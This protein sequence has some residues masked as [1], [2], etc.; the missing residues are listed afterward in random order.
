MSTIRFG[1]IRCDL[2]AI[3]YANIM[4]PHDVTVLRD[5][6]YGKG[7]DYYFYQDY[8]QPEQL[9]FPI[10]PGFELTRVWSPI[11][12]D[13][14]NMAKL[15]TS[16]PKV[17]ETFEEVSDD[18]DLVLIANC[19]EDKAGSDHLE[20]A[21]P[22]IGKG[23]PTFIDKPMAYEVSDAR[24]CVELAQEHNTPI[25]SLSILREVPHVA[26]FRNRFA[27]LGQPQ[28]AL[29]KGGNYRMAGMVHAISFAQHLFG[30]GVESV[31]SM[32][33]EGKP[34]IIHLDY[35]DQ[36]DKP[37][38]GVTLNCDVGDTYHCA[39]Y[40]SAYSSE[41]AIHSDRVSDFEFPWGV[42]EIVKKIKKMVETR[43][44]QA[45]YDEMVENIAVGTAAR[46][47]LEESRRV[48]L[49]EV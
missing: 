23:V 30:P 17:C 21:R 28:F 5:I 20:F 46:K 14:E 11:R 6:N 42:V 45:P 4:Q 24:T 40:A 25:L 43:T 38:S 44:P 39:I 36:A 19:D 8:L 15:Y 37:S 41:G 33:A 10:V 3:Y 7:G 49:S 26:R 13:A 9:S 12:Q 1:I 32:G 29:I 27:E 47:S 48:R 31:V 22:S 34:F 18:V 16:R 2:H 35:G